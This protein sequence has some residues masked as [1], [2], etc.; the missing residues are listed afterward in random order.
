MT[1]TYVYYYYWFS[2]SYFKSTYEYRSLFYGDGHYQIWEQQLSGMGIATLPLI[3]G[4]KLLNLDTTAE[5]NL[6]L[7]SFWYIH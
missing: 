1:I 6:N 7:Q 3:C 5:S 2:Y 4:A